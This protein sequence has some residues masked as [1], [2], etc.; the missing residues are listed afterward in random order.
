[1]D[2]AREARA[3][4]HAA[5]R[6]P[7][8][9]EVGRPLRDPARRRGAADPQH[10][11]AP[12]RHT[13]GAAP[14]HD[15]RGRGRPRHQADHRLRPHG[16][17][18]ELRGQGVLEGHHARR[19][20]GLP[21]LLLQRLRV[22]RRGGAPARPRGAAPRAVP[23]GHPPR[24]QPHR[25]PPHLARDRRPGPRR[26]VGVLVRL[27]RPR[28][29]PRP[30][31]DVLRPAD[32][33]PL[34]PGRRRRRGHPHGLRGRGARLHARVPEPARPVRG[35]DRQ[36]RDRPAAPAQRRRGR[37]GDAARPGRHRPAP[38]RG[39][40]PVG[41][42]QGAPLLELRPLRLRHPGRDGRRQLRP[43][44]R[45]HGGD[46]RVAQDHRPGARRPPRGAVHHREPQDRA[47]AAPRARHL[48]GGADP[49]LQ[50]R[51]GGLPRPAGR[52]LLPD[53]V[54]ARRARLLRALRRVEQAGPRAHARPL[55]R[56]PAG[57]Q[58]D[59]A[60]HLHRRPHRH[61]RDA[62]PDPRRDRPV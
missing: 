6:L 60:G 38:A 4:L 13:R 37:R 55:V 29:D 34:L 30:L 57:V 46:A 27:A 19:A 39:R 51:D 54:A 50:A 32:A 40:Q 26:D 28:P 20:D 3:R 12:P 45:P 23:A 62:R 8:D 5:A 47:A 17:R 25:L 52:G 18:E 49:P 43:L 56:E 41:P 2:D 10:G 36:E 31:R 21:L 1:G 24:A 61:A 7:R 53:R 16:H 44:P 42:A 9:G 35:P 15:A 14:A 59:G 48:D 58:A 22:L 11:P 33:H